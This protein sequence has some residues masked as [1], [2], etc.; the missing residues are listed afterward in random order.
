MLL[1][2]LILATAEASTLQVW[3]QDCFFD[4]F[5][6][7]WELYLVVKF[8]FKGVECAVSEACFYLGGGT[9]LPWCT[10]VAQRIASRN[11]S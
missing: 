7:V 1:E 4:V 2:L 8:A 3:Q 10:C 9:S 6:K 11:G 5:V